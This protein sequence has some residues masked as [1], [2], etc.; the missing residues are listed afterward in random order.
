VRSVS[1]A[2]VAI[3]VAVAVHWGGIAGA[4]VTQS[5][6][7]DALGRVV[8][9]ITADG[10]QTIYTYDASGNRTTVVVNATA[11]AA[12]TAPDETVSFTYGNLAPVITPTLGSNVSIV[13][14]TAPQLGAASFTATSLTYTPPA[15]AVAGADHFG[16][17]V[18]SSTTGLTAS[19][20]VTI[21]LL[22]AAPVANPA[23]ITVAENSHLQFTP[24]FSDPN[25]LTVSI[26]AVSTPAH[27]GAVVNTGTSITYTPTAGFWCPQ[28]PSSCDAFTYTVKNSANLTASAPVS[29][30]VTATP[31]VATPLPIGTAVNHAITFDPRTGDSD[32][33][34]LPLSVTAVGAPAHG[35]ATINGANQITYTPA[36]GYAGADSF[37]YTITNSGGGSASSTVTATVGGALTVTVSSTTWNWRR[38]LNHPPIEQGAVTG[39][40]TGGQGPYTYLWQYVSG[41]TDMTATA[42]QWLSTQWLW[43]PPE[44]NNPFSSVWEL[45]VSDA[46]GHVA[47][48]PPVTVT[49]EWDNS[50]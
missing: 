10:K 38:F 43:F 46:A 18:K 26:S 50:E 31:P 3:L 32:P 23:T 11:T 44:N 13:G 47:F 48:S 41:V 37:S 20:L 45:K 42:P 35:T 14:V 24:S 25:H 39:G 27:G 30:V 9:V 16:Y 49:F 28:F 6:T 15:T 29:V 1:R 8:S 4:A 2:A 34:G 19:A 7:Y 40:V 17:E 22:N 12:P 36:S 21:N 33:Q 5:V